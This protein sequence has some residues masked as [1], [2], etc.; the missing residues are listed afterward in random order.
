MQNVNVTSLAKGFNI[1]R[2]A[3]NDLRK[4]RENNLRIWSRA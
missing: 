3:L 1:T 2:T 4:N